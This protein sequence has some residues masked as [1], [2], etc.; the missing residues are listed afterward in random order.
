MRS[1]SAR[2]VTALASSLLMLLGARMA[3]AQSAESGT[4]ARQQ[5]L[6]PRPKVFF[7]MAEQPEMEMHHHH[8][9]PE[10]MPQFPRLGNSQRVV[11]GA[12][13]QL[14]ELERMATAHNPTLAQAQRAIEAARGREL[15]AGL[16]PNPV[17][18]D[19]G[20]EIRGGSYGGGEQGFFVEQP[21]ILGGKLG[22]H[23]K[24]GSA[25]G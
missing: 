11:T 5:P 15:Q 20:E 1:Q 4:A 3:L 14:E 16:Y 7:P 22:L 2:F 21:I 9:I 8:E 10:V 17:V 23:C 25:A 18:G 24:V 6:Q 13:Y 12:I 19:L